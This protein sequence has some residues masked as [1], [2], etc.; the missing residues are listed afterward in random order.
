MVN[1]YRIH[2]KD[3]AGLVH[4]SIENE[5]VSG[6]LNGVAPQL[7]SNQVSRL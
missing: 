1:V 3:L 7:V 4:Y 5:N 2:V 6:V